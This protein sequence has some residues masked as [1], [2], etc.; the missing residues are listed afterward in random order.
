[1]LDLFYENQLYH[2]VIRGEEKFLKIWSCIPSM[3]LTS[4]NMASILFVIHLV[5]GI[6]LTFSYEG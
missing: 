5:F 3:T 4:C 6:V 1:M 2:N